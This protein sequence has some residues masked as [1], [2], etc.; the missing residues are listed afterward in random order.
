MLQRHPHEDLVHGRDHD[1]N[2]Q[3]GEGC[4]GELP[5]LCRARRQL[6]PPLL[7]TR[8]GRRLPNA[9]RHQP[10]HGARRLAVVPPPA[11]AGLS[12]GPALCSPRAACR[13]AGTCGLQ[14]PSALQAV[15]GRRHLQPQHHD[16]RR[17]MR[18]R[19]P[20]DRLHPREAAWHVLCAL[21]EP[22]AQGAVP[23]RGA[24]VGDGLRAPCLHA[25]RL[26]P[27]L[28]PARDSGW[29]PREGEAGAHHGH[30]ELPLPLAGHPPRVPGRSQPGDGRA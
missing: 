27:A 4:E 24:A 2:G 19:G 8:A 10:Q 11:S 9:I 1:R 16:H 29:L 6:H 26:L 15:G 14:A 28:G 21:P 3:Q 12:G 23:G 22:D 7:G 30:G 17:R 20:S 18:L 25:G 5:R 13:P